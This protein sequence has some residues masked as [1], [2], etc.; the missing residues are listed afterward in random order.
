MLFLAA[1][2]NLEQMLREKILNDSHLDNILPVRHPSDVVNVTFGFELI[3]IVN[4][5]RI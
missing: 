2:P 5:V 3:N 1:I 4:V